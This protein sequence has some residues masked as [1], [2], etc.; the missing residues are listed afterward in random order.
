MVAQPSMVLSMPLVKGVG[1][2]VEKSSPALE[3]KY[4][5]CDSFCA[6]TCKASRHK[7]EKKKCFMGRGLYIKVNIPFGIKHFF[8]V[9]NRI[10]TKTG[11]A[12]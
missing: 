12:L 9:K 8:N 11:F 2:L 5:F 1:G 10:G 7:K 6:N 4:H 3:P